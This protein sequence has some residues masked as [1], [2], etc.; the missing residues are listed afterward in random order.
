MLGPLLYTLTLL[1]GDAERLGELCGAAPEKTE[2]VEIVWGREVTAAEV[3]ALP[4]AH[5][6]KQFY[7]NWLKVKYRYQIAKLNA[8]YGTEFTSFTD[9]TES[10]FRGFDGKREAVRAD[11]REFQGDFEAYLAGQIQAG[12]GAAVSKVAWKRK[13]T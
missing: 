5:D 1:P 7:A 6:W 12:C 2:M 13:R 8:A 9:L 11:D 10:D 4:S 3:R